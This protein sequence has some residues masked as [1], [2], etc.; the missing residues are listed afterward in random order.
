M[1]RNELA[2]SSSGK[3]AQ[4]KS[5]FGFTFCL[6]PFAW[7][8]CIFS[9]LLFSAEDWDIAGQTMRREHRARTILFDRKSAGA[10]LVCRILK[11]L[12][13]FELLTFKEGKPGPLGIEAKHIAADQ[14]DVARTIVAAVA[15]VVHLRRQAVFVKE[16]LQRQR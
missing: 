10:L 5:S 15:R 16:L 11:R 12:D 1:E 13:H 8:C 7:A 3:P 4:Q 14:L 9:T 6:G 2:S